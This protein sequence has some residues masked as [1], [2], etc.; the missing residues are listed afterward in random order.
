MFQSSLEILFMLLVAAILGFL[1]AWFLR[2]T[3]EEDTELRA[4]YEGNL[5]DYNHLKTKYQSSE[6]KIISLQEE[7]KNKVVHSEEEQRLRL[8]INQCE[9]N[10]Q[11]L[12][13]S[14][15][16]KDALIAE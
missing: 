11:G 1:I 3:K 15:D 9:Q 6:Q 8:K 5:T 12:E 7:L 10:A 4:L 16:K 14:L 13:L 2:R